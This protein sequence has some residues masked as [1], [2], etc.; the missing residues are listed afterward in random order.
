MKKIIALILTL[1][2]LL[3]A[4]AG[5]GKDAGGG[6]EGRSPANAG[7]E[8]TDPEKGKTDQ[9]PAERPTIE[10]GEIN[11][12][13]LFDE[14][15]VK[16]TATKLECSRSGAEVTLLLENN[17]DKTLQFLSN[18]LI[19][20]TNSVNGWM[21]KDGYL[22]VTVEPGKNAYAVVEFDGETLSIMGITK[23]AD[24]TLGLYVEDENNKTYLQ[25]GPM[26]LKTSFADSF[27]YTEDTYRAA[28]E[29]DVAKS[30]KLDLIKLDDTVSYD[31]YGIKVLSQAL[32]QN[33]YG[34]YWVLTEIE[35]TSKDDV[36]VYSEGFKVNGLT[37]CASRWTSQT[38]N[39]GKRMVMQASLSSMLNEEA[40]KLFGIDEV[41]RLEY[42]LSLR[43]IDGDKLMDAEGLTLTV[44]GASTTCDMTAEEVYN[45]NGI[46]ISYK[47]LVDVKGD[48]EDPLLIL[49]VDNA[50]S[51]YV[52][53]EDDFKA[54][55]I[56][57]QE[58]SY[59][60]DSTVPV[61]NGFI[62]DCELDSYDLEDIGISSV[63]DINELEIAFM[64][65]DDDYELM[66]SPVVTINV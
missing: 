13:V 56:N 19:Y 49:I 52:S 50:N 21:I 63:A 28:I 64:I 7:G 59:Y 16:I 23:I 32:L 55:K 51:K 41:G 5:C 17:T 45:G 18:T 39:A 6:E 15:D 44:P 46:R 9:K 12:T 10:G 8:K 35:N 43:E 31:H 65:Y 30:L 48:D 2:L 36:D 3:T 22:N 24:I 47:G 11:E 58:F 1:S 26:E 54:S 33:E 34:D 37:L 4:L 14:M 61:G 38:V 25:T 20:A 42:G 66:A 29:G 40:W 57:G 62:L 60:I 53:I 27:D